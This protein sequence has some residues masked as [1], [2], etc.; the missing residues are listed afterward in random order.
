MIDKRN[1]LFV[2]DNL[3]I[4]A[5]V[6]GEQVRELQE[7]WIIEWAKKAEALGYDPTSFIIKTRSGV[8]WKLF[9]LPD[10]SYNWDRINN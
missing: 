3:N 7:P 8:E 10:G 4:A 1:V 9:K 5:C 6:N 2:F